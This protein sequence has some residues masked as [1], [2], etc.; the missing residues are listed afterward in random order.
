MAFQRLSWIMVLF[1]KPFGNDLT[2]SPAVEASAARSSTP[3]AITNEKL[4]K[5]VPG[6]LNSSSSSHFE[7]VFGN[8]LSNCAAVEDA[9]TDRT[10]PL[11][12]IHKN[13][14]KRAPK[15]FISSPSANFGEVFG[16]DLSNSAAVEDALTERTT[17]LAII[18]QKLMQKVPKML[19][20]SPSSHFEEVF[21]NDLT[22]SAAVEDA[23][24]SGST[25]LAIIHE[26]LMKKVPRMLKSSPSSHVDEQQSSRP[27]IIRYSKRRGENNLRLYIV[28]G[29]SEKE[30]KTRG[31]NS[32]KGAYLVNACGGLA[33]ISTRNE[34]A[35][36]KYAVFNPLSRDRV[37]IVGTPNVSNSRACGIFYH[38]IAK[39]HRILAVY[40]REP[41]F[42]YHIYSTGSKRWRQTAS[43]Y[44]HYEPKRLWA[45]GKTPYD[46]VDGNPAIVNQALHW[47]IGGVMIFDM[48][49]EELSLR[50]LPFED[51]MAEKDYI[52]FLLVKEERLCFC[53]VDSKR[54]GI[55]V[56]VLEDYGNW[57]SWTKK[58]IASLSWDVNVFRFT[59]PWATCHIRIISIHKDELVLFWRYR[60]LFIY[61]LKAHTVRKISKKLNMHVGSYMYPRDYDNFLGFAAYTPTPSDRI[62]DDGH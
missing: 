55:D 60:G 12:I 10:T 7:E 25:P 13:L 41:L 36:T 11:V 21:G 62:Y 52:A 47:H 23:L 26:K 59:E 44:F 57:S 40:G 22:N 54:M 9:L 50:R 14:M 37:Q 38:P 19:I 3:Q 51:Y 32:L 17:P 43:P 20:P 16:N 27:I 42:E 34:E 45:D 28:T 8:D 46:V 18:H 61:S 30:C 49:S 29:N 48:V 31:L 1:K 6:M 5:K 35:Y 56:W 15:M 58:Y 33:L 4:M 2:N 53:V 39:E 24:T